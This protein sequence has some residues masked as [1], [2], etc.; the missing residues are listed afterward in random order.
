M[1]YPTAEIP[2]GRKQGWTPYRAPGLVPNGR[3][4]HAT[5]VYLRV[6]R[7]DDSEESS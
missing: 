2:G 5:R 6:F 7:S 4:A 3:S 1:S